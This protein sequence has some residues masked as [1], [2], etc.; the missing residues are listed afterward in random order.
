M[1]HEDAI[2][3]P[4]EVDL[5]TT[6]EGG[7]ED[8]LTTFERVFKDRSIAV[9]PLATAGAIRAANTKERTAESTWHVLQD[10]P[11]LPPARQRHRWGDCER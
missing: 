11:K 7:P 9:R 2:V 3:V 1:E 8:Q 4:V 6:L 10:W 5:S